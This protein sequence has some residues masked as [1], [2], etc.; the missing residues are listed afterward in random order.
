MRGY[1]KIRLESSMPERFLSLCVHN[2]IPLRNLKNK[3][4]YYEM[5]LSVKDFFRL[6]SFRRKTHS[7]IVLLEKHGMPFFFQRNQK[8]KAFFLGSF[9]FLLLLY[10]CSLF[11]WDIRVEGNHYHSSETI[12]ETLETFQVSDGM[13]KKDLN[14]QKIAAQIRESFP[15]VVWVSAKIEGTCLILEIKENE[16]SFHAADKQTAQEKSWDLA[17]PKDGVIVQMVTRCGMP[18]VQEG[19]EVKAGEILVSGRLEILNNDAQVQRYEYVG[20]DADITIQ[21]RYAYYDEFSLSHPEKLYTEEIKN[22]RMFRI[23]GKEFSL[24]HRR[25]ET[26]EIYRCIT[27]VYLTS[28]FC[29][30]ISYGTITVVPYRKQTAVYKKEEAEEIA[31]IHLQ[32]F[33]EHLVKSGAE[34][35]S[36]EIR[37]QIRDGKCIARGS[38]TVIEKTGKRVPVTQTPLSEP[39][40]EV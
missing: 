37:T 19:Q 33:L 22:Y 24:Y 1:V 36:K 4:F 17:A 40:N 10:L 11:V 18:L 32:T 39:E 16:D 28:S 5:E 38:V 3:E 31:R 15:N 2:Q 29:L 6:Q 30:P 21:T 23:F 35:C 25:K 26:A 7:R 20:A 9:L 14:C 8:R 27:P 34:I 12:L 13:L